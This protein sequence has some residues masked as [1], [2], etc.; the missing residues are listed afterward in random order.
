M[1]KSLYSTF[2][3]ISSVLFTVII[4]WVSNEFD[5]DSH[6]TEFESWKTVFAAERLA[7]S[8]K[9]LQTQCQINEVKDS[10]SKNSIIKK[11]VEIVMKIQQ[12]LKSFHWKQLL[13]ESKTYW[14]LEAHSL[15]D[16]FKQ[17]EIDHFRSHA[18]MNFWSEIEKK[19]STVKEQ[20]VLDCMWVYVY[21]FM[22][23]RML[24][25]CKTWLVVWEDQQKSVSADTYAGIYTV[26]LAVCF[27]HVFMIMTVQF[28]LKLTQYDA[29]NIFM[30]VNLNE[31]IFMK[32]SDEYW[33]TDHILKLNKTLYKLW[34]FSLLWQ[35]KLKKILLD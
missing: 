16:L 1:L 17:T 15:E 23:K 14:D 13:P 11:N 10:I 12:E 2:S 32:M 26:I 21:K 5:K 4:Y 29:V 33:K 30:H 20:Q 3:E 22:K 24:T 25:K 28:D 6:N 27:F 8:E 19:N 31:M 9:I 7:Q 35:Q 18:Q 34:R